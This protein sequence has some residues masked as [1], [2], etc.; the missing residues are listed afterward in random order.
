VKAKRNTKTVEV[1]LRVPVLCSVEVGE[2]NED[3][4]A[5]IFSIR[6]ADRGNFETPSFIEASALDESEYDDIDRAAAKAFEVET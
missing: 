6:L 3:G 4:Q 2:P 5:E 1:Y